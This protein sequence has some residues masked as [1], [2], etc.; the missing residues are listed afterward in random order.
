MTAHFHGLQDII[1]HPLILVRLVLFVQLL[2]DVTI[3]FWRHYRDK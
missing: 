3:A 1:V 2:S